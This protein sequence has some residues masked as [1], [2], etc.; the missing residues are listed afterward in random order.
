MINNQIFPPILPLTGQQ[1]FPA[2]GEM[3]II[4]AQTNEPNSDT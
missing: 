3:R 1:G 2:K 4:S